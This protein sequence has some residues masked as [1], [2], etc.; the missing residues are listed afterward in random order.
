M[1]AAGAGVAVAVT[2]PGAGESVGLD[3]HVLALREVS[4]SWMGLY[5]TLVLNERPLGGERLGISARH[6]IG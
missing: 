5:C 6:L 1:S 2:E 4:Q 3:V